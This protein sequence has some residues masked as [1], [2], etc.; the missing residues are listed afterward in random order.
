MKARD[1]MTTSLVLVPPEMPVGAVAQ[2]LAGRGIS[3]VPVT[4]AEGKLLG[5]VTEGDLIRRLAEEKR[6]PLGWFLALFGDS[7]KLADRFAKAH[8]ARAE[9]VMTRDLVTV[10]EDTGADEIARLMERHQ[11]RRVPVLRDGKLAGI[12]SRADLLRAVLN[13]PAQAPAAEATDTAILRKVI[14][15]MREQPWVDTFY[16]YPDVKEGKVTFYGFHR[17]A[18]VQRG[19]E[20][21]AREVPGVTAVEDRTEPMPFF[22]RG[23]L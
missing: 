16:L 8:G 7:R 5:L 2:T 21:L 18:E 17:S 22:L 10:G 23:S 4:D 15:A 6:G 13:P 14:A 19:L 1:L 3:A 20:V 12:V 11:I 9:D